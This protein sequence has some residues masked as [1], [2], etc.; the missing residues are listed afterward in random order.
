MYY[1]HK[2]TRRG[3]ENIPSIRNLFRKQKSSSSDAVN[4]IFIF[5]LA[6]CDLRICEIRAKVKI[7]SFVCHCHCSN[8]WLNQKKFRMLSATAIMRNNNN[9]NNNRF[10]TMLT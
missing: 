9:N 3:L 2:R 4:E 10:I 1:S 8:I 5:T 7:K 6:S